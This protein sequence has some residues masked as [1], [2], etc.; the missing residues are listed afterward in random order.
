M[1]AEELRV[2]TASLSAT[3]HVSDE[4]PGVVRLDLLSVPD[5]LRGRGCAREA[6]E[7]ITQWADETG[8]AIV[9]TATYALGANIPR[10][11]NL[12]MRHGFTPIEVTEL[13]E[14]RMLRQPRVLTAVPLREAPRILPPE[15][16]E[17]PQT[18][19]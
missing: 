19:L 12:Y 6:L 1:P 10:L 14:V 9:L 8:S 5:D 4:A 15:E 7:Q 3:I 13:H 17:E 16:A 2:I 18:D 11:L